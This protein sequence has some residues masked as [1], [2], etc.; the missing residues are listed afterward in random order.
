MS[1][2]VD[3]SRYP[4]VLT[5]WRGV[6]TAAD[7]HRHAEQMHACCARALAEGRSVALISDAT[8]VTATPPDVKQALAELPPPPGVVVGSWVVSRSTWMRG[9]V[10]AVRWLNPSIGN[11][12]VVPTLERALRDAAAALAAHD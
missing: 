5:V 6:S 8:A 1:F 9:V 3:D 2:T 7:I 10:A 12:H 4:I 11:V